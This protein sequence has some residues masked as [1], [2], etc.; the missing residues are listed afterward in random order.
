[1]VVTVEVFPSS[2][3]GSILPA[4]RVSQVIHTPFPSGGERVRVVHRSSS[5]AAWLSVPSAR[6]GSGCG[7]FPAGNRGC[8]RSPQLSPSSSRR[9]RIAELLAEL[10]ERSDRSCR[11]SS[12][13]IDS[14]GPSGAPPVDRLKTGSSCRWSSECFGKGAVFVGPSWRRC[15]RCGTARSK[16]PSRRGRSRAW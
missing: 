12:L 8:R 13:I 11:R 2:R 15:R 5:A 9:T 7:S 16:R 14:A 6:G 3:S 10:G 1:M 4:R